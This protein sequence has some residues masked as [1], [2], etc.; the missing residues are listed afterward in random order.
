MVFAISQVRQVNEARLRLEI[1]EQNE[2]IAQRSY[3]IS[4]LQ[5]ENG[6]ITSQ[7]LGREQERLA[8]TRLAYL[9]AFITYQL[10]VNDLKRK[11]LWDFKENRSYL[12]DASVQE[13]DQ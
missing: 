1:N 12:L 4:R 6:D 13:M 8:D 7:E 3:D 9:D 11:T 2:Q 5:F 10:A